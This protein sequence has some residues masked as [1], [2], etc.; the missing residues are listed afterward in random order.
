MAWKSFENDW[1]L[2]QWYDLGLKHWWSVLWW[3]AAES[4]A[5]FSNSMRSSF[6]TWI[7][8]LQSHLSRTCQRGRPNKHLGLLGLCTWIN[9]WRRI[10]LGRG[11]ESTNTSSKISEWWNWRRC[12][13]RCSGSNGNPE[14]QD[15]LLPGPPPATLNWIEDGA[16]G[17]M[18]GAFKMP[19][20]HCETFS[21]STSPNH[22]YRLDQHPQQQG[23]VDLEWLPIWLD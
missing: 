8:A 1:M 15:K 23:W 11:E 17:M 20:A 21:S 5:S 10:V 19:P 12:T 2:A 7:Q 9:W 18:G 13:C 3:Q 14:D 16:A 22:G 4:R 6:H